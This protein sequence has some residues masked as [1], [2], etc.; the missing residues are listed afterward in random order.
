VNLDN[1]LIFRRMVGNSPASSF[2]TEAASVL[3]LKKNGHKQGLEV[4]NL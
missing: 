4:L 1:A 2:V 3:Y